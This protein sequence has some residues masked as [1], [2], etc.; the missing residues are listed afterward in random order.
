MKNK[1]SLIICGLCLVWL[2]AYAG[3]DMQAHVASDEG[4]DAYYAY[5]TKQNVYYTG[6]Y[7]YAKLYLQTGTQLFGSLNT[8]MG[9][10]CKVGSSSYSYNSLRNE[11]VNVDRDLNTT[12][13]IIGYYDGYSFRGVWDSG[14]TWNR[15]HTWPQSK[16]ANSGIPMGHDMQSVRP[17]RTAVNSSRG[18][19][20]YGE[21][22]G[23]YD[24]NE[25]A[26]QNSNYNSRNKGTYRGDCA[27]VV[28]YD[29]I[30]YGQNDSYKNAL[31]NGNA[32]LLSKLGKSGVF[33][34]AEILL[35]WHMQDPPSL[36]EMVRNDGAQ[37]Y[38]GNRNPFI[39][40]PEFAIMV[41]ANEVTTYK[42]TSNQTMQP[43]Y[44]LT[45]KYGFVAYLTDDNGQHPNKVNV[46]GA[47]GSYDA[48][49]GRLTVTNVTSAVQIT[50]DTPSALEKATTE[51]IDFY[52]YGNELFVRNLDGQNLTVYSVS[53]N[54]MIV[55]QS[56]VGDF[57]LS[58]P[59]GIYILR[60]GSLTQKVV[61]L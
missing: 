20:A 27:R 19:T 3:I 56:C 23:Y 18:N 38:Q 32:Q 57:S 9:Q 39:D 30:V 49:L 40:Y 16:G 1:L 34:S 4:Q 43:N 48:A 51:S 59:Q 17:T 52:V 29:Y 47:T 36:T 11:Y 37:T 44:P 46:S 8:L 25:I 60:V 12:G 33:E 22:N 26:I 42:V 53:G 5:V 10:T 13:Y 41:L 58:L 54:T 61:I 45:T 15:E 28:L 35:K 50:T 55:Q 21:S 31:Y 14:K 2:S 6:N 24:P 7:T